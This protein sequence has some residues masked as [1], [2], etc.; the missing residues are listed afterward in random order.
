[1]NFVAPKPFA[2]ESARWLNENGVELRRR[3]DA[4]LEVIRPA[5]PGSGGRR[6]EVYV[7]PAQSRIDLSWTQVAMDDRGLSMKFA[8]RLPNPEKFRHPY[9]G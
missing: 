6:F 4:M 3:F 7:L 8:M 9:S 1:M 5:F 2:G